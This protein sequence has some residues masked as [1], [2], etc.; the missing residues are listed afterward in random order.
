MTRSLAA[1]IIVALAC[2]M[3]AFAA[4]PDCSSLGGTAVSWPSVDPVWEMC[5]VRP[6]D[7][8]PVSSG[9]SGLELRGV[10]F[11]GHQVLKRAHTPILNVQYYDQDMNESTCFRDWVNSENALLMDTPNPLGGGLYEPTAPAQTVCDKATDPL[12]PVG[13]CSWGEPGDCNQGVAVE[14]Y[15]DHVVFTSHGQAGWYRYSY[16]WRFYLDGTIEPEF[17]FGTYNDTF[18]S[19]THRHH[20]Y[21]R[22]DFDIDGPANDVVSEDDVPF[23]TEASRTW[24]DLNTR[25]KVE[26]A[27]AGLG[28]ELEPGAQEL[29]LPVDSFSRTDFMV[30]VYRST[31]LDDDP[32]GGDSCA[33]DTSDFVNGESLAGEDVVMWYRGGVQDTVDVDIFLCKRAQPTLRPI[34]DW[35]QSQQIFADGFESGNTAAWGQ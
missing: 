14:R 22:L 6:S 30:A 27:V 35:G 28:Y 34:G 9:G 19:N 21:W 32:P 2:S 15:Q 23:T 29:L 16:R 1:S 11:R 24:T 4:S 20:V 8:S 3:P 13:D 12:S 25:W 5:V 10:H 31:E 33:I 17:G 26:D 18:S 7:S